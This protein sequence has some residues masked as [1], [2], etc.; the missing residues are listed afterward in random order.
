MKLKNLSVATALLLTLTGCGSGGGSNNNPNA[1]TAINNNQTTQAQLEKQKAELQALKKRLS[2]AQANQKQA[3]E[4]LKSAE[5]THN[6]NLTTAQNTLAS[7]Q[8]KLAKTQSALEQAEKN[9]AVAQQNN[10]D[11]TELQNQLNEAAQKLSLAQQE[12]LQAE[13]ALNDKLAEDKPMS[14][15]EVL[16]FALHNGLHTVDSEEF[17]DDFQNKPKSFVIDQLIDTHKIIAIKRLARRYG[18]P[19]TDVRVFTKANKDKT[20]EE[21]ANLLETKRDEIEQKRTALRNELLAIAK[22]KGLEDWEANNFVYGREH[23]NKDQA[24]KDLNNYLIEKAERETKLNE[25]IELAK[26]KG[27]EDWEAQ[28]FANNNA[29]NDQA[30]VLKNLGQF[31]IDRAIAKADEIK[32]RIGENIPQ[33]F[34]SKYDDKTKS[35]YNQKAQEIGQERTYKDIYNQKYSIIAARYESYEEFQ[36]P[37][38]ARKDYSL[39]IQPISGRFGGFETKVLPT[40][41]DATYKG[42]G[43]TAER[44]GDLTYT[45]DFAKKEGEGEITGLKDLGT[46]HL[47]KGNIVRPFNDDNWG[48]GINSSISMAA[49]EWKD[50]NVTGQYQ[51]FFYGPNAEE[52]AGVGALVQT[53]PN[54]AAK[55][56]SDV[57]RTT[58]GY[59]NGASENLL[60]DLPYVYR[61]DPSGQFGIDIG[62]GGTRGEIKK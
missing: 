36:D 28:N 59:T 19:E 20:L 5:K 16:D 42:I 4:K 14:R 55:K 11:Y 56:L 10:K 45:V 41:G 50:Q 15:A 58:T 27:L 53:P 25:L 1:N 17:A 3:E 26:E 34:I 62:F 33:G 61:N 49:E 52:I 8:N 43:F 12:K 54:N 40:E 57:F 22:E 44:Q 51:L 39:S 21:A 37:E 29:E 30:T 38:S 35:I 23:T 32:R 48:L 31:I 6:Q 18:L 2:Q 9:L 46:L 7:A 24:L 60:Q 47:D 13:K